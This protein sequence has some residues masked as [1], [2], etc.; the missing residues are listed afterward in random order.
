[1][2]RLCI[3]RGPRVDRAVRFPY[4]VV[5]VVFHRCGGDCFG[6]CRLGDWPQQLAHCTDESC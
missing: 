6:R 3:L 1:M 4:H 2:N 5:A